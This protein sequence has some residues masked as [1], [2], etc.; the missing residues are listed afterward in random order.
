MPPTVALE[1]VPQAMP[2]DAEDGKSP[3]ERMLGEQ[4]K[5]ASPRAVERLDQQAWWARQWRDPRSAYEFVDLDERQEE[6]WKSLAEQI[7]GTAGRNRQ[8]TAATTCS[9]TQPTEPHAHRHGSSA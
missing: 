6:L 2:P 9:T 3:A 5:T 4:E 8:R 1:L 7:P